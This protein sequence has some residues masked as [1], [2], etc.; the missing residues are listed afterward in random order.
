MH[1]SIYVCVY[2]CV[3]TEMEADNIQAKRAALRKSERAIKIEYGRFLCSASKLMEEKKVKL[4]DV[5]VTWSG[6]DSEMSCEACEAK[7]ISSFLMAIRRSQGPYTYENI[8]DLLKLLCNDEGEKLVAEYDEKLKR[9]LSERVQ[10]VSQTGK[11]FKVKIDKELSREG[12]V[13]FRITLATLFKCKT[14]EFILEDIHEGC[15][16]LIYVIPS[17]I[18]EKIQK[19][20]VSKEEEDFSRENILELWIERYL[21]SFR[22]KMISIVAK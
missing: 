8:A 17:D 11:K 20:V 7:D 4:A 22:Y 1:Y 18:A 15:I 14:E 12:I 16:E 21:L 6:Y 10:P 19:C 5:K 2:V 13:D 3:C 9:K